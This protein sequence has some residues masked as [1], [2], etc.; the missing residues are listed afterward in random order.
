MKAK[1]KV[2]KPESLRERKKADVR[3]ALVL[4]AVGLFQKKGFE[5]V[6]VDEI[7]EKANVS[8][9]TFFRYF[10]T[11]EAIVFRN[12]ARRLAAFKAFLV[13]NRDGAN[14]VLGLQRA[15]DEMAGLFMAERD[16]LLS[17]NRIVT[18]SPYLTARDIELDSRFQHAVVD[19]LQDG[20]EEGDA[21]FKARMTGSAIFG[22]VRSVMGDWFSRGCRGD[23]VGYSQKIWDLFN[24]G[25]GVKPAA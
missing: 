19:C 21:R 23:L 13:K 20:A 8:R 2:P 22:M 5:A 7:V 25:F 9:S 24:S 12:H 1:A 10:P 14:P 4:T 17:E 18:S 3:N 16:E 6:T 11:K 15:F